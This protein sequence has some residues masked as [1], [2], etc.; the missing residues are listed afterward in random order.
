MKNSPKAVNL[1]GLIRNKCK[2]IQ[3]STPQPDTGKQFPI[4]Q[5]LQTTKRNK[6]KCGGGG[7]D[8]WEISFLKN[9]SQENNSKE[10]DVTIF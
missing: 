4:C 1:R 2:A 7:E 6:Q 9:Y 3:R 8:K 5:M 10:T